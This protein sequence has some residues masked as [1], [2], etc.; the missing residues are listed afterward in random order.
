MEAYQRVTDEDREPTPE[1]LDAMAAFTGWG[2][3]GQELFQG[4]WGYRRPK[5]GWAAEDQWLRDHLGKE[6][7]ESAQASII[8]AHYTDPPTVQAIWSAIEAMGFKGG[9]VLEPAMGIGNFFGMMPGTL[10]NNS[11]L[12]GIELEKTTGT[13]AK[14]LYPRASVRIM[15][16]ERSKTPDGFYDLVIG[17]WPFANIKIADRR[18]DHLSP[19]LHDYFFV[20]ALDQV[21]PGGLVVGITSAF[22]MDGQKNKGVRQHLARNA[23]LVTA[24]RLPSGAFEKY[25]GTKVV[26]DLI[27]LRKRDE[28]VSSVAAESWVQA[29]PFVTPS[30]DTI[31]VNQYFIDNPS[32]VLGTLDSGSGTTY[33][34]KGM[35]VRRPDDIADQLAGIAAR[36]PANAY[37]PVRRGKEPRFTANTTTDR[38][39]SV[40]IGK[41]GGLYQVLGD[42]M[43]PLEDVA[44]IRTANKAETEK[45]L[46]QVKAL[47]GLRRAAEALLEADRAGSDD[48][49]VKRAGL[50]KDYQGFLKA[51]GRIN[52]SFGLTLLRKLN[53][54]NAGL[55][56]AL[57]TA[58][59]EPSPLMERPTVRTTRKLE[60]PSIRDA[61]VMARNE[62]VNLDLDRVAELAKKSVEEVVADL[63]V[64]KA[65]Y[66][67]PGGGFQ[68]SDAYLSGNVRQKLREAQEALAD[69]DDMQ[70]SVDA[71]REV[72]PPDVPYFQIEA[73]FGAD[74]I[75]PEVNRQFI[76]ETLGLKDV[77]AK[78]IVLTR[79]VTG[80]S[81]EV[82]DKIAHM[83]GLSD[84]TGAPSPGRRGTGLSLRRFIE[85]TM[86]TQT[87]TVTYEDE[88]GTHK[89]TKA[90]EQANQKAGDLRQKFGSWVWADPERRVDAELDYNEVM[91]AVATPRVD[92]SFLEFP[93]MALTR[94]DQ[95]F[96]LRQHQANAIWKGILNQRGIYGHEVGTGKT[97]TMTGIAVESRRY[98]LAR[99]PLLI[100]HNANSAAVAAEA[101]ETYPGAK[102]LYVNNLAPGEIDAQ[103]ARMATEDWDL[104]VI[105]HS[106]LDRMALTY[107][108]LMEMAA[109]DIAAYE[110]EA[111]E[112]A[113]AEGQKLTVEDMENAD[114]MKKMRLGVTAKEMVKARAR[115]IQTIEKQSQRASREGAVSFEQLGIDMIL[116]DESHEFKKPP[117]ATRM[118]VKGLNTG[119]SNKSLALRFL[120]SHVKKQRGGT[121][122]HVFTGTP[123]TNTLA[124]IYHQMFYV[125]DDIMAQNRVDSWDGF[126][127]T[128]ADT[129]SDVELTSTSEFENVERLAAFINVSELRRMAGQFLDIVFASDMPEFTPRATDG[130]KTISAPDLTVVERDF[131]ENGRME[132]PVGRPYKRI[133]NDIGPMGQDQKRILQEV[134]GHARAFKAANGKA[135]REI[136]MSGGPNAPIVFNNVPNRASMD[137]RLQEPDAEDHPL[138]KANRA[139]KNIARIYLDEPMSTQVLFMDEGYSDEAVSVKTDADGNKTKTKKR[140]FNLP[141]TSLKSW[142]LLA[143]SARKSP[144]SRVA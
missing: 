120:T 1:E 57:E 80:W 15:G 84:I 117:L 99:K 110:R 124:E 111:I 73:R 128:F 11:Q 61:F 39:F 133:I 49:E 83:P 116:V 91:N 35:I 38:R 140:K 64:S 63:L 46:A 102:I 18:Y 26:T 19:S 89:D 43:V 126:F 131:L 138:S 62:S 87:L 42:Q 2:S 23:E 97:I 32:H 41:D 115:L 33:G 71:L 93:G 139:V 69:G 29:V 123:I 5:D 67:T 45:R 76:I 74:W 3:F 98:G 17:N 60:D 13:M 143:S 52:D 142:W 75:K 103:M 109:D 105:P 6:G 141:A 36:V 48:A 28:P 24:F 58:K 30:G 70:A 122:V 108:T 95:P 125:M 114:T 65:I 106:L 34:Q 88:E 78:D 50:K 72:Q 77:G 55:I 130:G 37:K 85:A 96:N 9:R 144:S 8:N 112:A 54:P 10:E 27:V 79:G 104:I 53:D 92:G 40:V 127:K 101:Q 137:A 47:V 14:M 7:W 107:D 51:H 20:K 132:N 134:V 119:T 66:K 100:A 22:S 90:T 44:R 113:E 31:T 86:N 121:G 68:A 4:S 82:S 135:R 12:F 129:I 118:Q 136:M 21:R 56:A 25:A 94:G 16:Y 81:V 59:G